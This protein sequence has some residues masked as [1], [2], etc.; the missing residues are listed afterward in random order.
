MLDIVKDLLLIATD[1]VMLV[2][3]L[4]RDKE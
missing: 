1:V 3:I 4:K 2:I